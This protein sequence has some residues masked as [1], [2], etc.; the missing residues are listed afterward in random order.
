MYGIDNIRSR[1]IVGHIIKIGVGHF[2]LRLE[3]TKFDLTAELFGK[4]H[5][6]YDKWQ[7]NMMLWK[8]HVAWSLTEKNLIQ[9]M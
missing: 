7:I 4:F 3:I 1:K 9:D 5:N 8:L 6:N 2:I